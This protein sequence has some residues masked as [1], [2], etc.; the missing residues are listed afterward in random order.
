VTVYEAGPQV[1]GLAAG[2][3]AEGWAW[4]LEKFY[5]HWFQ[6]DSAI[7]GLA[8]EL[9]VEQKLMW[10]RPKTVIYHKDQW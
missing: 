7:I 3:R 10:P 4:S 9:G 6:T 2:F 1:G 5:H 8:R